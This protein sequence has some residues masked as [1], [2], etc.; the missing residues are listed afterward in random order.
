MQ[1]TCTFIIAELLIIRKYAEMR[2][3]RIA[4]FGIR[5]EVHVVIPCCIILKF[6][7]SD[8]SCR[9]SPFKVISIFCP[10]NCFIGYTAGMTIPY[11]CITGEFY[12]AYL[13]FQVGNTYAQR[14]QFAGKFIGQFIN[15]CTLLCIGAIGMGHSFGRNFSRFIPRNVALTL[16]MRAVYTLDDAGVG[17]RNDR[18][19]CPAV[20]GNIS[21][22]ISRKS[23][24][25]AYSHSGNQGC[26]YFTF[27]HVNYP[28]SLK[29]D[30]VFSSYRVTDECSLFPL[31]AL[32]VK[33]GTSAHANHVIRKVYRHFSFLSTILSGVFIFLDKYALFFRPVSPVYPVRFY[34]MRK[35]GFMFPAVFI[36]LLTCVGNASLPAGRLF[37]QCDYFSE[38]P[39]RTVQNIFSSYTFVRAVFL[40]FL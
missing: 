35:F 37:F 36:V 1:V 28:F 27:F 10:F 24:R 9:S 20:T 34:G 18:F 39:F 30:V 6:I 38:R 13:L 26:Q 33:N 31:C 8:L 4:D 22:R 21:K 14:I 25:S 15:N 32:Y 17:Q 5:I 40:I 11:P 16:E 3:H 23:A 7:I 29:C 12:C 19:V 2:R